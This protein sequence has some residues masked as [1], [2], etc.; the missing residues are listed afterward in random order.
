MSVCAIAVAGATADAGQDR[1]FEIRLAATI[2]TSETGDASLSHDDLLTD[3]MTTERV[4]LWASQQTAATGSCIGHGRPDLDLTY[5]KGRD[6]SISVTGHVQLFE[7]GNCGAIDVNGGGRSTASMDVTNVTVPVNGE[8]VLPVD[9]TSRAGHRLFGALTLRNVYGSC[10]ATH[11]RW[12][13]HMD[14]VDYDY[15]SNNDSR[16]FDSRQ[17]SFLLPIEPNRG[18]SMVRNHEDTWGRME[19]RFVLMM[20]HSLD[21]ASTLSI[22][23]CNSWFYGCHHGA[24][25]DMTTIEPRS[26]RAIHLHADRDGSVDVTAT[27]ENHGTPQPCGVELSLLP[28]LYA[29]PFYGLGGS[30]TISGCYARTDDSEWIK[31]DEVSCTGS[32]SSRRCVL[33]GSAKGLLCPGRTWTFS[34]AVADSD[35][36]AVQQIMPKCAREGGVFRLTKGGATFQRGNR[37]EIQL[38]TP[39]TCAE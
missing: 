2:V 13:A 17:L 30:C 16:A 34:N 33:G 24:Q 26:E 10:A 27:I 12:R 25:T 6:D 8:V 4:L 1:A 37:P 14:V 19:S 22:G 18:A 15:L 31:F 23:E 36:R 39:G 28:G 21:V 5:T 7:G 32:G 11:V 20:N 29:G 35:C 38:S 3:E 9:L